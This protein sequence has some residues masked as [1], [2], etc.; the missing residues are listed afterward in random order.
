LQ[1][2]SPR[3][4]WPQIVAMRN[5]LVHEYFG[6]DLDE[7]WQ[8]VERELPPLKRAIEDALAGFRPHR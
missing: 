1:A 6:V 7:V 2:G 5:I 3:I 4:P 8:A